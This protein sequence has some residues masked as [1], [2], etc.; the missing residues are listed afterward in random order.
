M[1]AIRFRTLQE[2]KDFVY[3][4]GLS[5]PNVAIPNRFHSLNSG[6]TAVDKL[7]SFYA[8]GQI[9]FVYDFTGNETMLPDDPFLAADPDRNWLASVPIEEIV[10]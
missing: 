10:I 4:L 2:Y 7:G 3:G 8:G 6:G 5:N 9:L 1:V